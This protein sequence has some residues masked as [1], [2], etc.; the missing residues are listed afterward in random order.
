[1][2]KRYV[3]IRNFPDTLDTNPGSKLNSVT[4]VSNITNPDL[5]ELEK[6]KNVG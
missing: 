3:R 2:F 4:G 6:E 5:V 1:M